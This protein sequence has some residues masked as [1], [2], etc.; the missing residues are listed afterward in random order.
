MC[1][2]NY[3][4]ESFGLELIFP[5]LPN[6]QEEL[7]N[8]DIVEELS[9]WQ[10]CYYENQC[11]FE[12]GFLA[13]SDQ[14]IIEL[15]ENEFPL[16]VFSVLRLGCDYSVFKRADRIEVEYGATGI[17]HDPDTQVHIFGKYYKEKDTQEI[18]RYCLKCARESISEDRNDLVVF[19]FHN[20]MDSHEI[21]LE[22]TNFLTNYKYWCYV[23]DRF[24]FDVEFHDF[25]GDINDCQICVSVI[26]HDPKYKELPLEAYETHFELG[27]NPVTIPLVQTG[28]PI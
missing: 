9:P 7:D 11:K 19:A 16:Y 18:G 21:T 2:P 10:S 23:C 4:D 22:F 26:P 3:E 15:Y 27:N 6:L 13:N 14:T 1:A 28:W 5:P 17:S 12:A 25:Y 24:L 20:Y 8:I